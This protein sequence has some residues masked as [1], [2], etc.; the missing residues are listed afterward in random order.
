MTQPAREIDTGA[1]EPVARPEGGPTL[2]A[3][4]EPEVAPEPPE[5]PEAAPAAEAPPVWMRA[6]AALRPP[7]VW[8]TPAPTLRDEVARALAGEHLPSH[9]VLRYAEAARA[10]VSALISAALLLIV[11]AN[12]SAARQGAALIALAALTAALHT[13]LT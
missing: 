13:L 9:P 2:R 5:A 8:N 4:P 6:A 3:V 7:D 10:L 12:R 11:H 1:P